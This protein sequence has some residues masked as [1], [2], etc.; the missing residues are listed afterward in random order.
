MFFFCL[1]T[2]MLYCT[3]MTWKQ[4]SRRHWRNILRAA[5][6]KGIC[7][8]SH[9]AGS[10]CQR[11]LQPILETWHSYLCVMFGSR[12]LTLRHLHGSVIIVLHENQRTTKR[13]FLHQCTCSLLLASMSEYMG[14]AS[15][16]F[17]FASHHSVFGHISSQLDDCIQSTLQHATM[18]QRACAD[19]TVRPYSRF[20]IMSKQFLF[21]IIFNMSRK[22]SSF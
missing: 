9:T 16:G 17:A 19:P 14:S 8:L 13:Q 18:H 3:H 11:H 12:P 20:H 15:Q 1:R 5:Y 4:P 22:F 10:I 6:A 21:L 7:S 2:C